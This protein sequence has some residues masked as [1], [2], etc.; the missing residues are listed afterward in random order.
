MSIAG[1][2]AVLKWML[3]VSSALLCIPGHLFSLLPLQEELYQACQMIRKHIDVSLKVIVL[4]IPPSCL[5]G[6][7]RSPMPDQYS[8]RNAPFVSCNILK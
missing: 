3:L 1:K 2:A 6:K 8:L 4:A 5:Q 7:A